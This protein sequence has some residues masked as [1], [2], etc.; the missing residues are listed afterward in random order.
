MTHGGISRRPIELDVQMLEDMKFVGIANLAA[1]GL[2][3]DDEIEALLKSTPQ[4]VFDRMFD[5]CNA[6]IFKHWSGRVIEILPGLVRRL[7]L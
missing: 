1:A 7:V 3:D 2:I 5:Y 4:D 6:I